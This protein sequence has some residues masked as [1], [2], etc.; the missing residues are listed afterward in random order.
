[1]KPLHDITVAGAGFVGWL[2]AAALARNH[3][4]R[5][6][7]VTLVP[8]PGLDDSLD[9]F[10]PATALLPGG[11]EGLAALLGVTP[12]DILRAGD[13]GFSLGTAFQGWEGPGSVSFLPFGQTGADLKGVAFHHLVWRARAAGASIRMTDYSLSTLAA[14][15]ERFA[16]P[17]PDPRSVLSTLAPG[18]FADLRGLTALAQRQALA[19]GARLAT[20]PLSHVR[21][22]AAGRVTALVLADDTDIPADLF[23]DATGARALLAAPGNGW[24]DWRC[25]LPCD[26]YAVEPATADG[27]PPPYALHS[28]DATGWTRRIPLR[29]GAWVTRLGRGAGRFTSG[30]RDLAWDANTVLLGASAC[31]LD[32][33]GG[34]ALSL[35]ITTIRHLLSHYPVTPGSG[36]EAASFNS[37]VAVAMDRARDFLILR[38]KANGRTGEAFWDAARAMDLPDPLAHKMALYESRGRI[39]LYDG[40]LFDRPDWINLLDGAGI[41]ARRCDVQA[42]GLNDGEIMAHLERLRGVLLRAAGELPPHAQALAQLLGG[43][44]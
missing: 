33:V 24:H 6:G 25:W 35:L 32:P 44:P 7:S 19:A 11:V 18:G 15:A 16:L 4:G 1:M 38:F 14:Q 5:G 12:A 43:T 29:T 2:A 37:Q 41:R 20:A 31:L 28:A 40:E 10:G 36:P 23:I 3:A 9:P 39:P 8:L 30:R 42:N 13:G 22:D 17:S 21:R 26:Q 34:V 27:P